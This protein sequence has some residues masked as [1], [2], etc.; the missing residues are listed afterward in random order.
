MQMINRSEMLL[1]AISVAA[2][3]T[4]MMTVFAYGWL[5]AFKVMAA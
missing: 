2:G 3:F 1:S 4:L 5:M